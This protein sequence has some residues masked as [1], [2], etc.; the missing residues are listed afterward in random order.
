M[1]ASN[2]NAIHAPERVPISQTHQAH[3]AMSNPAPNMHAHV[4]MP[5]RAACCR[6]VPT[7]DRTIDHTIDAMTMTGFAV[8]T[9]SIKKKNADALYAAS[10]HQIALTACI[11]TIK[12][13]AVGMQAASKTTRTRSYVPS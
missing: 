5:S 6:V 12:A 3:A 2:L 11:D 7:T 10:G 1:A 9:K 13:Q 4:V 8:N